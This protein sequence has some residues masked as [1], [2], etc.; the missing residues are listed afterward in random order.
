MSEKEQND[1]L[2]ERLTDMQMER[3]LDR[4]YWHDALTRLAEQQR[5]I[6]SEE[7]KA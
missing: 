1:P 7:A 2:A 4:A 3:Q 6:P 5:A